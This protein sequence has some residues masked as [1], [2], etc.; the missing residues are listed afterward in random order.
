MRA[1]ILAAGE[2]KRLR[3]HFSRPKPLVRL[4]GLTLI[5]RNILC[6]RECGINDIII[7]TG[8]YSGEI[9][10]YLGNG[11]KYGVNITYLHNPDWKLGNGVSAFTFRKDYRQGE[12]FLLIMSDHV[13]EPEVL[14]AFVAE[15]PNINEG[16]LMLAADRRLKC[17]YDL[18]ECTKVKA[19]QDFAVRL[20]KDLRDFNAVDC[21]LFIGTGVLLEALSD[22][23]SQCNYTL[24]GAVNILAGQHKVKLH[25]VNGTWIDVDD[26]P[27]Y[28]HA[29]KI[30]LRSLVPP[31]DGLISRVLNRRVSLWITKLF[32]RTSITPNK[33][34]F[35][36][37]LVS[38]ASAAFFALAHPFYG[39][40]LAQL[41]S[42]LDGVDGEIARLKFLKSNYG[43]LFDAILDRYADFLIVL[44]MAY[45]WYS[46]T[47][48]AL[49]LLACATALTG[50][51]M[52]M[53]L[54]E[55]FHALTGRPFIPEY[56]DGILRYLPANRDGRL[57]IIM[58]GGILNLIP[59]TI[60]FL[61]IVTHLQALAR[62]YHA[63]KLM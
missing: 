3:P 15:A 63:R 8:C 11:S 38:T 21:G 51:P 34:T 2:G 25:F 47:G 48:D 28:R 14:K 54:K 1:V 10:N 32:A 59:A 30:L 33:V 13:F 4:L 9:Q 20:G 36:S 18:E 35:L 44:G 19:E 5:E 29:E 23:I 31:K 39:G 22:A 49:A 37:F 53:L 12:K 40:L 57:F 17:V 60:I 7:I 55:K 45:A 16:E 24:T 27:S 62:L 52:S 42:I 50:M 43:G 58:L 56:Y 6:L 46:K 61:A 41:S 26:L